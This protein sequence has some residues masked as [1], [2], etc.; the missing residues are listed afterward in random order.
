MPCIAMSFAGQG[1]QRVALARPPTGVGHIHAAELVVSAVERP[2]RDVVAFARSIISN[3]RHPDS[4][5]IQVVC[6]SVDRF[7]IEPSLRLGQKRIHVP[8]ELH[9]PS[10]A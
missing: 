10:L 5:W 8:H 1:F 3:S 9:N 2:F 7:F 4:R 6:S